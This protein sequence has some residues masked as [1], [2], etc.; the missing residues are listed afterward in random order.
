[1]VLLASIGATVG[2][3]LGGCDVCLDE[4][5]SGAC[6][7]NSILAAIVNCTGA[8]LISS[9][10]LLCFRLLLCSMSNEG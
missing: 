8:Y 4:Y 5:K 7:A 6:G 1:M 2:I 3:A 10:T 9:T